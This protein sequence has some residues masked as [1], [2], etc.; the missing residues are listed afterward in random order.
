MNS[1][2]VNLDTSQTGRFGKSFHNLLGEIG[3][4]WEI[5]ENSGCM[6]VLIQNK[7]NLRQQSKHIYMRSTKQSY[8]KGV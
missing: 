1:K 5:W 8:K 7:T 2:P 3:V 4:N 6:V